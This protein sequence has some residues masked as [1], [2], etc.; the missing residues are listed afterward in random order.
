[1]ETLR[2][3]IGAA[4]ANGAKGT[5]DGPTRA[6]RHQRQRPAARRADD[7]ANLIIAYKNGAP[8][9]LRDVANVGRRRRRTP[10]SAPG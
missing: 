4:N 8:V 2:T 5:F 3:A 10:S 1:M 9:R 7:Y 6:V